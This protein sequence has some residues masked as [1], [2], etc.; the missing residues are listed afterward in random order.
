MRRFL[1]STIVTSTLLVMSCDEYILV[2]NDT[3]SYEEQNQIY[4]NYGLSGDS[5]LLDSSI[6]KPAY[7]YWNESRKDFFTAVGTQEIIDAGKDAGGYALESIDFC[8]S[9]LAVSGKAVSLYW[10]EEE[11]DNYSTTTSQDTYR[12]RNA[13]IQGYLWEFQYKE[14]IPVVQYYNANTKDYRLSTKSPDIT[15]YDSIRVEGYTYPKSYCVVNLDTNNSDTINSVESSSSSLLNNISSSSHNPNHEDSCHRSSSS[16]SSSSFDTEVEVSSSSLSISSSSV[17]I[18]NEIEGLI[19]VV[20]YWNSLRKDQFLGSTIQEHIDAIKDG[21]GYSIVDSS[22]Y[23]MPSYTE[24]LV[25]LYLYWSE[26]SEDNLSTT[27]TQIPFGF[28]YARIQGYISS[29]P[30]AGLKPL[31]LYYDTESSDYLT[32]LSDSI[33][34]SFSSKNYQLVDTLG[35]VVPRNCI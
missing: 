12:F 7:Q 13:R 30:S 6:L 11:T 4:S 28:R 10:S 17:C 19:P 21:G 15:G 1:I 22:F 29:V 34:A 25:P 16:Y 3:S 23:L 2:K 20:L 5:V 9:Q 32:S 26:D 14:M 27:S 24:N 31:L 18:Q 8:M 33:P 35:Y